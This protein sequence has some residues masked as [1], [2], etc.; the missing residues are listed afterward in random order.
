PSRRT[1]RPGGRCSRPR[2]NP[3]R[4][5][6]RHR[7]EPGSLGGVRS[8][9]APGQTGAYGPAHF[10]DADE[11]DEAVLDQQLQ[12]QAGEESQDDEAQTAA[13]ATLTELYPHLSHHERTLS[14]VKLADLLAPKI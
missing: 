9:Q 10:P 11:L 1:G 13:W 12:D 7:T 2:T 14:A 4:P 3:P 5:R 8:Q 6:A